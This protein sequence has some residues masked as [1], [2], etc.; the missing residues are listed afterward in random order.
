[1][2]LAKSTEE[3]TRE[4]A[5]PD[6]PHQGVKFSSTAH[7]S[8]EVIMD[9]TRWVDMR[10]PNKIIVE[11]TPAWAAPPADDLGQAQPA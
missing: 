5:T 1:M 7:G 9:F 4:V 10:Y 6:Q 3:L 8:T 2:R 11:I